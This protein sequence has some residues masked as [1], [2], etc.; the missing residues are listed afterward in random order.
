MRDYEV[1]Y[2]V[3]TELS[4]EGLSSIIERYA[5]IVASYQGVVG[6][7]TVMGR[8]R[9][10][11]SIKG[12]SE[13]VYVLMQFQ[14][15]GALVK[16][17][18]RDY[19][20]SDAIIRHLIIRRVAPI[21]MPTVPGE[22]EAEAAAVPEAAAAEAEPAPEEL[23]EPVLAEVGASAEAV[24]EEQVVPDAPAVE[25]EAAS[26][27]AEPPSEGEAAEEIREEESEQPST[28]LVPDTAAAE[29][30]KGAE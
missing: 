13:G 27:E 24:A 2:I 7:T 4:Q 23:A 11:Y 8:R 18:T 16:E 12:R 26:A 3:P 20:Q 21:E 1:M 25:R 9:L 29:G 19:R 6:K 14:G 30:E 17:L 10:G 5:R 15:D 28:P 22:E